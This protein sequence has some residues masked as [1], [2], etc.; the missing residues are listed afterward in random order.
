MSEQ[1][2]YRNYS[3]DVK[4]PANTDSIN[5]S[6]LRELYIKLLSNYKTLNQE[7][8]N[9]MEKEKKNRI[10]IQELKN[11]NGLLKQTIENEKL[12]KY[13]FLEKQNSE[14]KAFSKTNIQNEFNHDNNITSNK[15]ESFNEVVKNMKA[16]YDKLKKDLVL[17]QAIANNFKTELE[18]IK[19]LNQNYKSENELLNGNIKELKLQLDK[20]NLKKK[21]IENEYNKNTLEMDKIKKENIKIQEMNKNKS[22]ELI[23]KFKELSQKYE[24][25]NESTLSR[26][27]ELTVNNEKL[28]L[29]LEALNNQIKKLDEDKN[30][31]ISEL[32]FER[33]NIT[34][35]QQDIDE[36]E[37]VIKKLRKENAEFNK[38]LKE[39]LETN[40]NIMKNCSCQ[41]LEK[42]NE[43][44]EAR[45]S[46]L[47]N[48]IE[49][50]K[51]Q[52]VTEKKKI[53][54]MLQIQNEKGEDF[55]F[56]RKL[57]KEEK[58][59]LTGE[60]DRLTKIIEQYE[61][62]YPNLE[63]QKYL[64]ESEINNLKENLEKFQS[65]KDLI[66]SNRNSIQKDFNQLSNQYN[67]L[68]EKLEKEIKIK[69]D[70]ITDY[71]K[72]V[73]SLKKEIIKL[74]EN[75]KSLQFQTLNNEDFVSNLQNKISEFETKEKEAKL[76]LKDYEI[77]IFEKN[78]L[79]KS[80][81]ECKKII[82]YLESQN[83]D[84]KVKQE[85]LLI[86]NNNLKN[87]NFRLINSQ[88]MIHKDQNNKLE[89]LNKKI[90]DDLN[91]EI[92]K[93]NEL[94]SSLAKEKENLISNSF[95][96]KMEINS[97]QE[98]IEK[99]FKENKSL[100]E[101]ILNIKSGFYTLFSELKINMN[102]VYS[103]IKKENK[104]I[105]QE[106]S[107]EKINHILSR[108]NLLK[109]EN[110]DNNIID[111]TINSLT[112]FSYEFD[113]LY[114]KFLQADNILYQ[115]NTINQVDKMTI[116][117]SEFENEKLINRNEELMNEI[118]ALN[119]EIEKYKDQQ[120]I[121]NSELSGIRKNE[122]CDFNTKKKH[123]EQIQLLT[124]EQKD[125]KE[126]NKKIITENENLISEKK[127]F[128]DF[129]SM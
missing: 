76:K 111:I 87:E 58:L 56:E 79:E 49:D 75:R 57:N 104:N 85:N 125:L 16:E 46:E 69:N 67:F 59:K 45:I 51:K 101:I 74:K 119:L 96:Y 3:P 90:I 86:E 84:G 22:A 52:V 95:N 62:E 68:K 120:R 54:E 44:K 99:I 98:M 37:E 65:E 18:N 110:L 15:N 7:K 97:K 31:I 10:I 19:V 61:S 29:Q 88:A 6:A 72:N 50:L 100:N 105:F 103:L 40:K 64:L 94:N 39:L 41:R 122:I 80:I 115:S 21:E 26:H 114:E 48:Q 11:E 66:E 63:K 92:K 73:E 34:H 28:A 112:F 5:E 42:L 47:K 43:E 24:N 121:M 89:E 129:L 124:K 70:E 77:L 53:E 81:E 118:N 113:S 71:E 55:I 23:S 116:E 83:K 123:E 32:N 82:N 78:N 107:Y 2:S 128:E 33:E 25:N 20:I 4:Y 13:Q 91:Q 38:K 127:N 35:M 30:E 27:A 93:I 1:R 17:S 60:I 14:S 102:K 108:I 126:E 9:L 8:I 106:I 109:N 12:L 36:K 117:R